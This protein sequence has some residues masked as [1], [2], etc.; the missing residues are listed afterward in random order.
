MH[1][2]DAPC[3]PRLA[4]IGPRIDGNGPRQRLS[5]VPM[6]RLGG[7]GRCWSR[8]TLSLRRP[9][10]AARRLV[11][12]RRRFGPVGAS[13]DRT[14]GLGDAIRNYDP[15][16]GTGRLKSS[17]PDH[18]RRSEGQA[19]HIVQRGDI[20][21]LDPQGGEVLPE[22]GHTPGHPRDRLAQVF[23]LEL[24][25]PGRAKVSDSRSQKVI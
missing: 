2:D 11:V 16:G 10:R 5:H 20:L 3:G 18:C 15:S 25:E 1:G 14:E 22:K 19:P 17:R 24:L 13:R 9:A 4:Q 8:R 7:L 21:G 23:Q 12:P 6:G